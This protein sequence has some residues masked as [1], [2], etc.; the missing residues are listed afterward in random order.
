[1]TK[2][3]IFLLATITLGL[4]IYAMEQ[5]AVAHPILFQRMLS[6]QPTTIVLRVYSDNTGV[7]LINDHHVIQ[8]T[9]EQIIWHN[10]SASQ[11]QNVAHLQCEL[12]Q[13]PQPKVIIKVADSASAYTSTVVNLDCCSGE[14]RSSDP[15]MEPSSYE[16]ETEA[17][18]LVVYAF[19]CG[20]SGTKSTD[21][22]FA[23][24]YETSSCSADNI[25]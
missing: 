23:E 12:I 7:I 24:S 2:L 16:K 4:K 13:A 9:K 10:V 15:T 21:V 17:A 19:S 6:E 20:T 5:V 11:M 25:L 14:I 8:L 3:T 18:N 1:M 22:A